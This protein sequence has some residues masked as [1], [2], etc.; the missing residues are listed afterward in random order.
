MDICQPLLGSQEVKGYIGPYCEPTGFCAWES[1]PA[2]SKQ[3]T[4]SQVNCY[5]SRHVQ[6]ICP[7]GQR[8][9]HRII[10]N[11]YHK[12]ERPTPVKA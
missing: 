2:A 9:E 10:R 8:W 11:G 4:G 6:T 5:T 1:L 7:N 3:S 12:T